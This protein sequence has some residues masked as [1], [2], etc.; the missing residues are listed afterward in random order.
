MFSSFYKFRSDNFGCE[1]GGGGNVG[2][3]NSVDCIF[4]CFGGCVVFG[5]F[6]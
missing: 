2:G 6:I 4:G 1:G 5:N 3:I